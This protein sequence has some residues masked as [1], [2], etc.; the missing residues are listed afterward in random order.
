MSAEREITVSV[1]SSLNVPSERALQADIEK[2]RT[3]Q[4]QCRNQIE[5]NRTQADKQRFDKLAFEKLA[6]DPSD[7]DDGI[8]YNADA[9]ADAAKRCDKHIGM[10]ESLIKREQEKIDHLQ[11]MISEIEKR[12]TMWRQLQDQVNDQLH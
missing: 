1:M 5:V 11:Y 4:E 7:N 10:F 6:K 12:L 3:M 2:L 9:C 8:T